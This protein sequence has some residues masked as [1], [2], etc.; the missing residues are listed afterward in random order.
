MLNTNT[1][2]KPKLNV[3]LTSA[4]FQKESPQGSFKGTVFKAR[5]RSNV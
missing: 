3:N 5:Y 4:D 2:V 1:K